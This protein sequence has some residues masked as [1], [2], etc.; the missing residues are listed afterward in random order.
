[1]SRT[2]AAFAPAKL[3]LHLHVGPPRP[4]GRHP[5]ESL[6]AFADAGDWLTASPAAELSLEVRG[7][8]AAALAAEE[9]NLVLR[10][11]RLLA[12]RF[13]VRAGAS[14]TLDK[15][16]P[17]A[18]GVGGGSADAAAALR[19]LSA[20]WDLTADIAVLEDIARPLGS[21]VPVCL[22]CQP[23]WMTGGGEDV[24][25]ADIAPLEGVLVNPLIP[26]PTGPVYRAFD[27]MGLGVAF[28]PAPGPPGPQADL[29]GWLREQRNDLEGPAIRL[30]PVIAEV[31]S[32]LAKCRE[33]AL[34]RMSGSGA[35]CFALTRSRSD[36]AALVSALRAEHP[37][38][39]VQAVRIGA[40]DGAAHPL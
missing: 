17:I 19:V 38:W 7:P 36:A 10:A 26:S 24:R 4:D 13:G 3:N 35:S 33:T 27:E 12:Q 21:D 16:L 2:L 23:A 11:A 39:W 34:A 29:L 20:L 31:L 18:S 15:R 1:M 28:Q 9:D 6:A 30:T 8:F 32:A 14:L 25:P 40:V 37:G 5:L 22:R